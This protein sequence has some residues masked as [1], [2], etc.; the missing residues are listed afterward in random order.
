MRCERG[1]FEEAEGPLTTQ[2]SSALTK[3]KS[4]AK[5]NGN[6]AAR[7]GSEDEFDDRENK[8]PDHHLTHPDKKA[9]KIFS[10]T[11]PGASV[12]SITS[13]YR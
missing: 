13:A 10:D 2:T 3:D 7:K 8:E 4:T 5:V 12:F 11:Y 6:S 1:R 9:C